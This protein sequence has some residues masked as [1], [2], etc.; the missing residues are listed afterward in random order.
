MRY[1]LDENLG[2]R[3]AQIFSEFGHDVETV[4]DEGLQSTDDET[5]IEVCRH[6]NSSSQSR[7][8]KQTQAKLAREFRGKQFSENRSSANWAFGDGGIVMT[9][10]AVPRQSPLG[11]HGISVIRRLYAFQETAASMHWR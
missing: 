3:G 2:T 6:E 10:M 8:L 9:R 4:V 5:L 1:K 7:H 11:R